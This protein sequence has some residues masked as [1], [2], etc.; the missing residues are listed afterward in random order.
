M[1]VLDVLIGLGVF[2][3]FA[4]GATAGYHAG[5]AAERNKYKRRVV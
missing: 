5:K 1:Y 2:V 3:V 4:M